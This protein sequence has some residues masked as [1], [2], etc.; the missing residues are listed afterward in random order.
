MG[1]HS[2]NLFSRPSLCEGASRLM[3]FSG[4]LNQYNTSPSPSEADTRS[5]SHDW[6]AIG[7]DLEQ[8]ISDEWNEQQKS[9]E[10]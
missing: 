2:F 9:Q 10:S 7:L 6:Q 1:N 3:D 4:S 5:L 8:A